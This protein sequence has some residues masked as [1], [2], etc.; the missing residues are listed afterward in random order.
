MD[1][2]RRLEMIEMDYEMTGKYVSFDL[3]LISVSLD[4]R[5]TAAELRR[6]ADA[7]DAEGVVES[8]TD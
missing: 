3:G 7:L 6:F 8:Y 1:A 5:F 4:G 2:E